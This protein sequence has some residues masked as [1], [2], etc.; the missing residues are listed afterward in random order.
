MCG[1]A[2]GTR[3]RGSTPRRC[4]SSTTISPRRKARDELNAEQGRRVCGRAVCE[5][6]RRDPRPAGCSGFDQPDPRRRG[7]DRPPSR[8][9]G[10]ARRLR[11][12]AGG[13]HLVGIRH[14]TT[15]ESDGEW[16]SRPD[17]VRGLT[18]LASARV[19]FDVVVE[20]WQLP[21]VTTLARSIESATSCSTLGN[22]PIASENRPRWRLT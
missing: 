4:R 2:R 10:P 8:C 22:P 15:M 9:A 14:V 7:L 3:S 21:L 11:A 17:V 13:P 20:P 18:S 12:A 6:P 16:L 1:S 5:C 19:P